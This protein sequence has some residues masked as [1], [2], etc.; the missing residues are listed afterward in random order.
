MLYNRVNGFHIDT[1]NAREALKGMMVLLAVVRQAENT[2]LF[3]Q[4]WK[5]TLTNEFSLS[6]EVKSKPVMG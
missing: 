3:L 2:T 5:G 4:H 6:R 1:V